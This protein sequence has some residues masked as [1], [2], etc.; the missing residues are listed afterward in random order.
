M[1]TSV[2][3]AKIVLLVLLYKV[4]LDLAY[5]FYINKVYYYE[6]FELNFIWIKIFES[7]MMTFIIAVCLPMNEKK[8]STIA[9]NTLNIIMILPLLTLYSYKNESRIYFYSFSI[10]FLLIIFFVKLVPNIKFRIKT[11]WNKVFNLGLIIM[12]I[13]VYVNLLAFNGLPS[14]E[15]LDFTKVYSVRANVNYGFKIM[16]YM[17]P[18][19]ANIINIFYMAIFFMKKDKYKVCFMVALQILIY[20]ITSHKAY[21]FYPIIIPILIYFIK[22]GNYIIGSLFG[23]ISV[24]I[25]S[26]ISYYTN[27]NVMLGAMFVNRTLFLP[28][29]ISFQYHEFFSNNKYVMLSHSILKP[30][31]KKPIYEIHP[32]RIIGTVYY[33]NNWPNTGFMGDAYMNFGYIGIIIFS[34]FV[35]I[36]LITIDSISNTNEKRL[37]SSAMVVIF[38]LTLTNGAFFTSLMNGGILLYILITLN[39]RDTKNS[40]EKYGC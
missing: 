19:Q 13:M 7:F 4:I 16:Q 10:S 25:V 2:K 20:L 28:A 5:I 1:K 29:Q 12:G 35:A 11:S 6:G 3:R 30:F 33:N 26:V 27:F 23:I 37:L 17:V 21:F 38:M 18:W 9:L 34:L 36:L 32:I 8:P 15:V 31:F 40:I 14:L 22:K 24:I 39:Y